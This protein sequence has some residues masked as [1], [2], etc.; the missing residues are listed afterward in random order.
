MTRDPALDRAGARSFQ[1]WLDTGT[2]IEDDEPCEFCGRTTT[3][4]PCDAC[5]EPNPN[6]NDAPLQLG[7]FT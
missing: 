2:D 7:L 1:H 6:S 4:G 5:T 3:E